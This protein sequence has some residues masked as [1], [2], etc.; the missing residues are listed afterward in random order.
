MSKIFFINFQVDVSQE[1]AECTT[2][3][4]CCAVAPNGRIA[5]TMKNGVGSLHTHNL[6]EALQLAQEIGVALHKALDKRLVKAQ[7]L[8]GRTNGFLL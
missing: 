2:V 8:S 7:E 1:E 5:T 4:L 6:I 3:H